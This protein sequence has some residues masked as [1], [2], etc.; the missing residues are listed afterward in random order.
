MLVEKCAME[1]YQR[2]SLLVAE[3]VAGVAPYA[4]CVVRLDTLAFNHY[5]TSIDA[6]YLGH[7]PFL[8]DRANL[9]LFGSL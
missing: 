3:F 1:S 5:Q 7:K 8:A 2:L 6:F 4:L 9:W